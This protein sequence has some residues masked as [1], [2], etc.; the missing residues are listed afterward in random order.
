[1]QNGIWKTKKKVLPFLFFRRC[2][3]RT[4]YENDHLET[5]LKYIFWDTCKKSVVFTLKGWKIQDSFQDFSGVHWA[6]AK[7][8]FLTFLNGVT[9][10]LRIITSALSCFLW[11]FLKCI[12]KYKFPHWETTPW[13]KTFVATIVRVETFVGIRNMSVFSSLCPKIIQMF[14]Q[15]IGSKK[16]AGLMEIHTF[17]GNLE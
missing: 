5:S 14:I 10:N 11:K 9:S 13:R 1:M 17:I 6:S 7:T 12:Q 8:L 15:V 16:A 3:N 4:V 2:H